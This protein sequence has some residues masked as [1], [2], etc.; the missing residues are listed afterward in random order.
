MNKKGLIKVQTGS[1]PNL[2]QKCT[3]VHKNEHKPPNIIRLLPRVIKK[4]T[5]KPEDIQETISHAS[6]D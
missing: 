5:K 6:H 1:I 3:T 4:T 2:V